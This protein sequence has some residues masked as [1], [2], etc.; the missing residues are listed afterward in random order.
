M[1]FYSCLVGLTELMMLAMSLHVL[2][3]S[4]F[5]KEQKI[6]YLLTFICVMLCAGAE[7]AVHCGYYNESFAIPLTILTVLQF[8]A[9]PILGVLFIGALGL[10]NQTKIAVIY[11]SINLVVETVAAFFGWIFYFDESGYHRGNYFLIYGA[12]YLLSLL[13]L[14]VGLVLV[15][16]KFRHRDM[17]TIGMTLIIL[18]AGILPMTILKLNITYTAIAMSASLCYIYYND[19]IQQDIKT[20]L[21]TKQ[22]KMSD[23]QDH[24]PCQPC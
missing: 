15:G 6:W 13:Y 19:L 16:K 1:D 18:I 21:V 2:T 3:Y 22:K 23:M 7:F 5:K 9:A 17:W 24:R 14:I 11:F 12:F 10:R 8:S 4:G 20:E